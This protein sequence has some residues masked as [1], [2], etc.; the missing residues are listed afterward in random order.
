MNVVDVC[1]YVD[2][3]DAEALLSCGIYVHLVWAK[4]KKNPMWELEY[5]GPPIPGFISVE[6]KSEPS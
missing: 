1:Y 2:G 6:T 4:K 5:Y 3:V